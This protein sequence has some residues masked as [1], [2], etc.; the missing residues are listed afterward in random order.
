MEKSFEFIKGMDSDELA[1]LRHAIVAELEWRE[2]EKQ[3][4]AWDKVK[5]AIGQYNEQF[6]EIII[7]DNDG[8][9]VFLDN[10]M[11]ASGNFGEISVY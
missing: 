4:I 5:S 7:Y 3:R 2:N 11:W 8:R 9:E 6:G 10:R 1:N